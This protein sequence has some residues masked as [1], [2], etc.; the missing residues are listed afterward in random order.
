MSRAS[1]DAIDY[2]LRPAK[3][4][5]R[6]MLAEMFR[7]L[8][9]A[10]TLRQYQYVGFGSPYFADFALFHRLLDIQSMISIEREV[11]DQARFNFNRPFRAVEL[12]FGDAS[13]VLPQL[14]WSQR[15]I[16]WLDY[17]DPL[18]TSML[19]DVALCARRLASGSVLLVSALAQL[20]LD[21]GE[22]LAELRANLQ[23]NVPPGITSDDVGGWDIANL[24][25]A[26]I[27]ERIAVAIRE[28]NA[29]RSHIAQYSYTQLVNFQYADGARMCTV[30]GLILDDSDRSH[31]KSCDFEEFD[32]SRD[33]D[34]AY[35]IKVPLLTPKEVRHLDAMLPAATKP[36]ATREG[37]PL[38][39]S[40]KYAD[41]YRYF[42]HYVDVE[43]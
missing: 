26:A 16:V 35:R 41:V 11:L 30:G 43:G 25:R 7:R 34:A 29:G 4:I 18:D 28:R 36:D 24:Y 22:R 32:F 37:I 40:N 21:P 6:K 15:R 13:E 17:D 31:F 10:A 38:T 33:G 42:P 39:Q 9:R 2:N 23:D 27:D 14:D 8:D 19:N 12:K 3:A 5:E 20:A 1:Y